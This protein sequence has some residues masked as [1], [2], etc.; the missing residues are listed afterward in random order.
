MPTIFVVMK[1]VEE[2]T[3]NFNNELVLFADD[4]D[5]R[6]G[7]LHQEVV[8]T[9]FTI[10][11]LVKETLINSDNTSHKMLVRN[12]ESTKYD[13]M[14]SALGMEEMFD[15]NYDITAKEYSRIFRSL[16]SASYLNRENSQKVLSW[17]SETNLNNFLSLGLPKD[18][19]FSH[20]IGEEFEQSVFLDSGIV[21]IPDRPY[22]I[23]VMIKVKEGESVELAS[24]IMKE[25]S[26]K[27]YNYVANY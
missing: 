7:D 9:R 14:I 20:K 11:R 23:T 25:I 26:E 12:I 10:E 3:W 2:G 16:Y 19:K 15:K 8:G 13:Q 27:S 22:L 24:K 4:K 21:Y 1:K 17:L 6:F 5:A 18:V